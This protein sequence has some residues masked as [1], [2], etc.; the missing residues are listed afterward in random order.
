MADAAVD[1]GRFALVLE[2]ELALLL[3]NRLSNQTKNVIKTSTKSVSQW[4]SRFVKGRFGPVFENILCRGAQNI[5]GVVRQE[6]YD[7]TALWYQET[8]WKDHWDWYSNWPCFYWGDW[9]ISGDDGEIKL[10][11]KGCGEAQIPH[12]SRRSDQAL[13]QFWQEHSRGPTSKGVC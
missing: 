9:S 8:F 5:R 12:N 7:N 10:W 4:I 1:S 6:I 11:R 3:S 13:C 2:D